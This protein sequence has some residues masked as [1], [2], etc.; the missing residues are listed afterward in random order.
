MQL[1]LTISL[2]KS[3][4]TDPNT[5]APEPVSHLTS[6]VGK[7]GFLDDLR[8]TDREKLLRERKK[9]LNTLFD[10]ADLQ[11]YVE[12][13]SAPT[14]TQSKRAMLSRMEKG[15]GKAKAGASGSEDEE[16]EMNEIQLNL[17]C[18]SLSPCLRTRTPSLTL[19]VRS[20]TRRRSRT[21]RACPSATRPTPSPSRCVPVRPL[22]P[23]VDLANFCQ[24]HLVAPSRRSEAGAALDGGDGDRRG[25]GAQELVDAPAV[26]E[27]PLPG[28]QGPRRLL[29]LQPVQRC[30][31]PLCLYRTSCRAR[32]D[33][34]DIPQ[35]S[36]RSTSPRRRR[37][38]AAASSPTRWVS[39]RRSWSPRC[40]SPSPSP[41]PC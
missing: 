4:F 18:A 24:R 31:P 21:T 11:P 38:A 23:L 40:A 10:K 15:K 13:G 6:V 22:C 17:V 5:A 37:T 26:G 19:F 34:V 12:D 16:D 41:S 8:E 32:T 39:A 20:Q 29:L 27:V 1:S 35:A 3:A 14:G 33:L 30:V 36:S 2:A 9:A 28:Q 25:A 7:K